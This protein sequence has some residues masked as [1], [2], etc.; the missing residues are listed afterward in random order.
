M[1]GVEGGVDPR[2]VVFRWKDVDNV[3]IYI[4]ISFLLIH[5]DLFVR[6]D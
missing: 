6:T 3:Y 5:N 2:G 4:I 1:G